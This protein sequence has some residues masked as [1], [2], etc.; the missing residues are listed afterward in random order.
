MASS[1]VP[2]GRDMPPAYRVVSR[3][4]RQPQSCRVFFARDSRAMRLANL[5]RELIVGGRGVYK[6]GRWPRWR[7]TRLLY[8]HR[9]RQIA[10]ASSHL[11]NNCT[12]LH[13]TNTPF[14]L[15]SGPLLSRLRTKTQVLLQHMTRRPTKLLLN[16]QI[17][18]N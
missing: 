4:H 11:H 10:N 6:A 5:I 13:R 3:R 8:D 15:V 18:I 7:A 1:C 2:N 12:T 9:Y 16:K 17:L 14:S